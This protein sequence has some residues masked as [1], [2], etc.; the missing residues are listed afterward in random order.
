MAVS[1]YIVNP[2]NFTDDSGWKVGTAAENSDSFPILEAKPYPDIL[3]NPTSDF[4][5]TL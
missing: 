2:S 5:A 3:A 1:N 4:E